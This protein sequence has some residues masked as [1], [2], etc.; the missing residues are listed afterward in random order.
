MNTLNRRILD[1]AAW[2]GAAAAVVTC[3]GWWIAGILP[4][5][6]SPSWDAARTAAFFTEEPNRVLLGF[7][8]SSIGVVLA[9]PMYALITLHMLRSEGRTPVL[10]FTQLVV[11]TVTVAI[12]LF[13]QL[14]WAV[15][16]FRADRNPDDIVL[17]NDLAWL[18][19]FPAITAFI[20]QN[21]AIGI[22]ALRDTT[23]IF[24]RW[25][26]Y[27]NFLVA[28]SFL[29]D[30]LAFFL[31]TGPFAWNGV[32]VFWLALT[33]YCVFLVAMGFVCRR[34]NAT[35]QTEPVPAKA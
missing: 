17:L 21:I 35:L 18:I 30:P 11:A 14:I 29:P 20:I 7:V 28:F 10:A 33:S 24:P 4:V 27:L 13:P 32:F 1:Y 12:N 25:I 19:V 26:G 31:K 8:V 2:G 22:V 23:G 16:A 15:A 6:M 3:I 9:A 34:A 5:P